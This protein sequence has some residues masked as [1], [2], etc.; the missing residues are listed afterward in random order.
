MTSPSPVDDDHGC[1]R[2]V[3]AVPLLPLTLIAAD[4]SW[5]ALT[6]RPADPWDHGRADRLNH[7]LLLPR[8]CGGLVLRRSPKREEWMTAV[9]VD[10]PEAHRR[11]TGRADGAGL[12][13]A[14]S[15]RKPDRTPPG[16]AAGS[17][18]R[19]STPTAP[20]GPGTCR[21]D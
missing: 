17:P 9:E 4:F 5:T 20:T 6:I 12:I 3:L 19:P 11:R 2:P 15:A 14:R 18:P 13:Q 10:S 16:Y 8:S 21:Y 7:R 1:L